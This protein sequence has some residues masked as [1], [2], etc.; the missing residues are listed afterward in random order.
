MHVYHELPR[1]PLSSNLALS[2]GTFDGVHRGH[3][4]LVATL[5]REANSR[6]L[7]AAVLTF[8]DMPYCYF[9]PDDCP[10]LLTLPDEKIGAFAPLK[11]DQLFIVPFDA[12]IA[13]QSAREFCGALVKNL[14]VKLLVIGPDFALG[15][16]REGDVKTLRELGKEFD[17]EVVVLD[18][19]LRD[20]G[21]AI[22]ST[23]VR[24]AVEDGQV[25]TAARLLGHPFALSGE[26]VSG[27]QLGRKIG[28]PTINI[29]PHSRKVLPQNGVYAARA[30]FDEENIFHRAA[31]NIGLRPTVDGLRQTI[32]FHV[33]GETIETPPTQARLE[34]M[35]RL[36]AEQK[37][38]DLDAL[39]KQIKSDIAQAEAILSEKP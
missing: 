35:A 1:A 10:H 17:F 2:I 33:I 13:Q 29:R 23:R 6:G 16:G 32:E 30:F 28:V 7:A 38:P 19:K 11:I 26:V 36:R 12:H 27:Q 25:E 31:L 5:N 3:Q 37:F 20:E 21:R 4:L 18:E 15:R 34:L 22:S 14:G 24:E 9:K 8:Q 39:V